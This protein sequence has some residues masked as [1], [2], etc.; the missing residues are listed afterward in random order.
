MMLHTK[1]HVLGFVISNKKTFS[2]FPYISLCKYVTTGMGHF[3][4]KDYNLNKL[5]RGP[6]GD[7]KYQM[8]IV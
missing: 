6:L 8:S 1:Y 3:W 7:T 4:P 5:G 2:H